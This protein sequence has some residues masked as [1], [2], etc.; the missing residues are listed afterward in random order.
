MR[1]S[2]STRVT[3]TKNP[4]ARTLPKVTNR[5]PRSECLRAFDETIKLL[6]DYLHGTRAAWRSLQSQLK[7]GRGLDGPDFTDLARRLN[8]APAELHGRLDG[9]EATHRSV[10][11]VHMVAAYEDYLKQLI[12]SVLSTRPLPTDGVTKIDVDFGALD[13]NT[14]A[15]EMVHRLWAEQTAKR[16]VGSGY[17]ERSREVRQVLGVDHD[18]L[19]NHLAPQFDL[20]Y[21]KVAC[22]MRNCL[23]HDGGRVD[24]RLHGVLQSVGLGSTIDS[25]IPLTD[26]LPMKLFGELHAHAE[27]LDL[28]VRWEPGVK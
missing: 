22:L 18:E 11:L 16:V 14:A 19:G 9:L 8:V 10:C 27:A 4:P 15:S 2:K 23:V 12:Q 17:A 21:V 6:N 13:D 20:N 26:Q 5:P 24:H 28:L 3:K 25:P 1:G 7:S